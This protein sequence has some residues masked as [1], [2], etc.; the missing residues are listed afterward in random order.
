MSNRTQGWAFLVGDIR[1]RGYGSCMYEVASLATARKDQCLYLLG[2]IGLQKLSEQLG[3][4]RTSGYRGEK[5]TENFYYVILGRSL[6]S[7]GLFWIHLCSLLALSPCHLLTTRTALW[8]MM[9]FDTVVEGT[10]TLKVLTAT[11][12]EE[13]EDQGA[14]TGWHKGLGTADGLMGTDNEFARTWWHEN[15]WEDDGGNKRPVRVH[16]HASAIFY[17]TDLHGLA[18]IVHPRWH[19]Q[20]CQ[21]REWLHYCR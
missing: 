13:D 9:N 21:R 20:H 18:F 5:L 16:S 10:V 11:G 12:W 14:V 7:L 6:T 19:G 15:E 8:C 2:N 17:F 3:L 1:D 4:A